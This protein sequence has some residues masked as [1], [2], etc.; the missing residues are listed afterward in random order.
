M[1][2]AKGTQYFADFHLWLSV[3][4]RPSYSRFSRAQRLTCALSLVLSYMAVNAA[5]YQVNEKEVTILFFL[6]YCMRNI[7][8]FH[9]IKDSA[10]I[11]DELITIVLLTIVNSKN[12]KRDRK[13]LFKLP[14][15]HFFFFI[16]NFFFIAIIMK[17]FFTIS[18]DIRDRQ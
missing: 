5:W 14:F 4:S 1:L 3:F 2:W 18:S 7:I 13:T 16:L 8:Y 17:V 12:V 9:I 6:Q 10:L 11:I 15:V